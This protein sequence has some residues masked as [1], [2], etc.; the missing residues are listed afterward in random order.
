VKLC[1]VLDRFTLD[2]VFFSVAQSSSL[3][4]RDAIRAAEYCPG[5]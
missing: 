3:S 2:E 4:A 1:F 5:L